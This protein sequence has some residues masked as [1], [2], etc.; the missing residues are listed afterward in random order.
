MKINMIYIDKDNLIFSIF[1]L[2]ILTFKSVV[3]RTENVNLM[4]NIET[5]N[6]IKYIMQAIIKWD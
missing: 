2:K 1:I 6:H 5:K 4:H 3:G